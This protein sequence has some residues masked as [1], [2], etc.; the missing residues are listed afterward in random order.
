MKLGFIKFFFNNLIIDFI[1]PANTILL[2]NVALTQNKS[3][4][5]F[6]KFVQT[7]IQSMK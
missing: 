7:H 5:T 6:W 4:L 1:V 2:V 3:W